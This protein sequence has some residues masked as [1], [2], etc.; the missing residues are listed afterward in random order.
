MGKG[1]GRGDDVVAQNAAGLWSQQA[2]RAVRSELKE[3]AA[4]AAAAGAAA[5]KG[6]QRRTKADKGR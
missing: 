3:A 2:A 6:G 4:A 5:A 1:K